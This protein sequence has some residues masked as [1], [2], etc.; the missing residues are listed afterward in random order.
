MIFISEYVCPECNWTQL[1]KFISI[2]VES[3][4][5]FLKTEIESSSF[6]SCSK[7]KT[8]VKNR[9]EIIWEVEKNKKLDSAL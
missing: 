2:S 5:I 9:I 4:S 6:K 8:A 1:I 3:A 7:C